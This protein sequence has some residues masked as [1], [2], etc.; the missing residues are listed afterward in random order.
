MTI[1]A[2]ATLTT[3]RA[4]RAGRSRQKPTSP[5]DLAKMLDPKFRIVPVTRLLSDLAVRAVEQPDQRDIVTMPPRSGKSRLLAIW[6]PVYALMRNPDTTVM[7]ISYSDELAQAHSREIRRIV[8]EHSDYLG[9]SIAADK[10]SVGRWAVEGQRA[11][12]CR[13]GASVAH[14]QR[15]RGKE[16]ALRA[17]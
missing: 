6:T 16:L 1:E 8:N 15:R 9:F 12:S 2:I 3:A 10:S 7:V 14:R 11:K 17:W 13:A 5:A 4:L